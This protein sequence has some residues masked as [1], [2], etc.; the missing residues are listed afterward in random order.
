M[1]VARVVVQAVV[2]TD[3][4]VAALVIAIVAGHA[5]QMEIWN[6]G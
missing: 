5:I 2:L 1:P 6:D 4:M 3:A